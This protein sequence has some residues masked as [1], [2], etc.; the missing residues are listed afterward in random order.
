MRDIKTDIASRLAAAGHAVDHS[1]IEEL[2]QHA[3]AA[4]ASARAEGLEANEAEARV[5]ALI[6]GWVAE[7]A[8]LR[9]GTRRVTVEPPP[10]QAAFLAGLLHDVRYAWRLAWRRPGPA[11]VAA[12]T[13]ALGNGATTTLFSV[14]WAVLMKPL[15]WTDADRIIRLQETR[16]GA[17][18][19]FP[20][21]MTNATLLAWTDAPSGTI[22]SVG[23]YQSPQGVTVTDG[24]GPQRIRVSSVT[25]SLFDVLRV[26]PFRGRT[27]TSAD[28]AAVN[29]FVLAH[30]YW[31]RQ[32][33]GSEAAVGSTIALDGRS[34][35]IIGVLP[36]GV[37]F[38]DRDTLAW[39]PFRVQRSQSADGGSS[40]QLFSAIAR[41]K[42]GATARQAADEATA[43]G[44]GLGDPGMVAIALFGSKGEPQV[45]AQ[46]MLEAATADVRD[47]L[48][49]LLIAVG[50]LLATATANV[51]SVQLAR[52]ASRRRELAVRA[53]IGAGSARLARQLIVEALVVG[54]A[55]GLGG[56]VLA[57]GLHRALPVVLPPDFPRVHE[58]A[59]DP[60]VI[61]FA[62]M[63][64][65]AASLAFGVA[66]ALQ[67]RRMDL[68]TGLSDDA[69][70]TGAGFSRT[71][72]ARMRAAIMAGQVAVACI[73][74]IGASL[75]VR[76]F[77]QM[78][79]AERGYDSTNVLTA[80]IATPTGLFT[81]E[82]RAALVSRTLERL[83]ARA[84]VAYAGTTSILP[85]MGSEAMMALML[86][87]MPGQP[88]QTINTSF[89]VVSHG[90]F[91]A[92]GI[93][94][95][96]GRTFDERDTAASTPVLVVNETFARRYLTDGSVGR[97]LNVS[98]YEK[99]N[100]WLIAGVVQDVRVRGALTDPAQPEMYVTFPQVPGGLAS[101]PV[102]V[103]RAQSDPAALAGVL[104]QV[105]TAEEPAATIES[106][107]T[108]EERVLNSLSRPRLYAIV[109]AGFAAFAL[110][111]AAVGLFGVLSYSVAQ[112]SRELGVRAALG[113]RPSQIVGLV[114]REGLVIC[115][116][117]LLIGMALAFAASRWVSTFLYGVAPHDAL[118]FTLAPVTLL[119]IAVVA[120]LIPAR[121]ASRLDPLRVLRSS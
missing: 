17:T 21:V 39:T 88:A 33:G 29:V 50:L 74:L 61:G 114:L 1:V 38:P 113:A 60:I 107:M 25:A 49:L 24:A 65:I 94:V 75:L 56:L 6:D 18:R 121:R 76:S 40:I 2:A 58:I 62:M 20:W 105:V 96:E 15:P 87:E 116:V 118:T 108:M 48:W 84:D 67:A 46:P 110:L 93:A 73:L 52:A 13:M 72:T 92:M 14:S 59:L 35:E 101:Q 79:G 103:V 5:S 45:S 51:A 91:E 78:L 112:R 16:E 64:T 106:V 30:D 81:P 22:E 27:F 3:E 70:A 55:G 12:L 31:L 63:V 89:R 66:P 69:A 77:E 109:L 117:G 28:E 8:R 36:P 10:T 9:H 19:T 71:R 104:R 82:R 98:L 11:L 111:I 26:P 42:P 90:Y 7:G 53:A 83:R 119:S 115:A 41:L 99:L 120:C 95:R 97:V 47:G 43:R 57:L 32:F 54:L 68:R 34:Y 100:G 80:R 23:A 85:L 37:T 86:P 4:F 102:I 44:S